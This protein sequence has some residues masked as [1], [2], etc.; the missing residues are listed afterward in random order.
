MDLMTLPVATL[1]ET[2]AESRLAALTDQCR[3]LAELAAREGADMIQEVREQARGQVQWKANPRDLVTAADR[4]SEAVIAHTINSVR[5]QDAIV[6][7]EGAAKPGSSGLRWVVDPLDGTNNFVYG[8]GEWAVSIACED[9]HG[10][11]AAA[12][13]H[14]ERGELFSAARGQEP[15]LNG[16]PLAGATGRPL[17]MAMMLAYYECQLAGGARHQQE[18]MQ[19]L[20]ARVGH[21][22]QH[23]S[24]AL[25]LAWVAAGRA[26]LYYQRG[27]KHWDLAAG[28]LLCQGAGLDVRVLPA[29]DE[30]SM[31]VI[32]GPSDLLDQLPREL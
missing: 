31:G 28:R 1:L 24:A 29:D 30:R 7:E 9:E 14:P 27:L 11:L 20:Y 5:P 3:A 13:F 32:A 23:G 26:D 19:A 10:P 12:I 18:V 4:A 21:I 16:E 22:R 8:L 17:E 2:S 15:T 6:G 25:G